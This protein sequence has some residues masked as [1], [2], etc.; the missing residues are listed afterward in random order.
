MSPYIIIPAELLAGTEIGGMMEVDVIHDFTNVLHLVNYSAAT[1]QELLS[2]EM[3]MECED[4]DVTDG[5]YELVD[6]EQVHER[7][8]SSEIE[9]DADV[10]HGIKK[11]KRNP[12]KWAKN[13]RKTK[14][15]C[16]DAY[17]SVLGHE[18]AAKAPQPWPCCCKPEKGYKCS[19]FSEEER[20]HIC[21]LYWQLSDYVRK[22]DW[23]I[24]HV[25]EVPVGRRR[26][27]QERITQR[28]KFAMVFAK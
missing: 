22:K 7:D 17:T 11:R 19:E 25:T 20:V 2:N 10:N 9:A 27:R 16:G 3:E 23:L 5:D 1:Y 15:Q 4:S 6:D 26:R 21:K 12:R 18:V 14:A 13:V 8:S 24:A 28:S